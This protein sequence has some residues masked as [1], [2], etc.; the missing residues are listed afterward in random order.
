[1]LKRECETKLELV[2]TFKTTG[3][4]QE[5][6][7]EQESTSFHEFQEALL[8][9]GSEPP[10]LHVQDMSVTVQL[11]GH[12]NPHSVARVL[13]L[14]SVYSNFHSHSHH[15]QNDRNTQIIQYYFHALFPFC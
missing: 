13:V 15:T 8:E 1:M 6:Q 7:L 14:M 9:P 2:N 5:V 3:D 11:L 10:H 12:S 4:L